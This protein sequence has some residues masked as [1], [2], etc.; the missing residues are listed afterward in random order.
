VEQL[1]RNTRMETAEHIAIT[2]ALKT[3]QMFAEVFAGGLAR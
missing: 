1:Q 2:G 3:W